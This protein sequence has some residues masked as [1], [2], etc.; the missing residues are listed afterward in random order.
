MLKRS[1]LFIKCSLNIIIKMAINRNF[2][3]EKV[4]SKCAC[5]KKPHG[6]LVNLLLWF[7]KYSGEKI[8]NLYERNYGIIKQGSLTAVI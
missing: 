5:G 7:Q 6:F 4:F 3:K 2:F 1:C 8:A